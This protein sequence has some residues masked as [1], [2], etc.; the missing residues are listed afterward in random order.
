ML[1]RSRHA[2]L[3][4]AMLSLLLLSC[5]ASAT[6]RANGEEH[7]TP[8]AQDPPEQVEAVARRLNGLRDLSFSLNS[9]GVC[10]GDVL[11]AEYQQDPQEGEDAFN[12]RTTQNVIALLEAIKAEPEDLGLDYTASAPGVDRYGNRTN[13]Y[14]HWLCYTPHDV[15][16]INLNNRDFLEDNVLTMNTFG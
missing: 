4:L 16:Q 3:A 14:V 7:E 9:Q 15:R 13:E 1:R 2:L 11:F 6:D 10:R 12:A 8:V 5:G